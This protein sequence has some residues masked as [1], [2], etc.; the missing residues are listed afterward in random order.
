MEEIRAISETDWKQ[1]IKNKTVQITLRFLNSNQ[2]SKSRQYNELK[3][4]PYLSPND[5]YIDF[6]TASFIA[7]TQTYMVENIKCN[8]KE[9][10]KPNLTCKS[11][12]I[13]ECNQ[14]HLLYCS[15]LLGSNELVTYIPE[16]SDIFDDDN[17]SEQ[18]YIATLLM[19]NLTQKKLIENIV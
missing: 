4:A 3:M 9:K 17:I 2:G 14:K 8:Y 5:E 7:K 13:S 10:F 16:Y 1:L 6:K 19:E 15:K 11:C 18:N 12:L